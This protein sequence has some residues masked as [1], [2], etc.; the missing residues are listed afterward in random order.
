MSSRLP[1]ALIAALVLTVTPAW[2][3]P[4]DHIR[5]GSAT[6]MP[7]LDLGLAYDN[8]VYRAAT[9]PITGG[10]LAVSPSL[11]LL[12]DTEQNT[13]ELAG[14]W[15]IRKYL[16]LGTDVPEKPEMIRAVDR[17]NDFDVGAKFD[18]LRQESVGIVIE[19]QVTLRNNETDRGVLANPFLTQVRNR[20]GGG[21]R[22]SPGDALDVIPGAAWAYDDFRIADERAFR[23]RF[24]SRHTYG[25][26]LDT[27]WSFFPRTALVLRGD[28][29][30]HW[31]QQNTVPVFDPLT[32]A[33]GALAVPDS[34]HVKAQTGIEGRFTEH[35]FVDLV[36]GYGTAT[37][38]PSETG[39]IPADAANVR[40]ADGILA[41]A[42]L[43]YRVARGPENAFDVSVGYQRDFLD[44]FFSNYVVYNQMQAQANAN[45][46]GVR[47]HLSY[48]I[49]FEEYSGAVMRHD[50]LNRFEGSL[51]YE[52]QEWGMIAAS[53]AWQ[54][55]AIR[56]D[57]YQSAEYDA[58][59]VAL[60]STWTY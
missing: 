13:F 34:L 36:G 57:A 27:T 48:G 43:R 59:T 33:A 42:Q 3:G 19:E 52:F 50:I 12:V 16:F 51:G 20:L 49:R 10:H 6:L 25:P 2:A 15:D 23:T 47:P 46:R 40:G 38:E 58:L 21:V 44:A 53:T 5:A 14:N 35:L 55:R 11:R 9:D 24:N 56:E 39:G 29:M 45:L 17:Y 60:T 8:N 1:I 7:Q 41:T 31:W 4:G 32:G 22:V 37:Y 18:L 26:T 30:W 54:Q 28:A